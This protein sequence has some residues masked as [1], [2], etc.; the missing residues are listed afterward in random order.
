VISPAEF[1]RCFLGRRLWAKQKTMLD[2]VARNRS[3]AVKGCHGSGKSYAAAGLVC[4]E[5]TCH[6]EAIVLVIAPTLRQVKTF[7]AEVS[8]AIAQLKYPVPDATT[9]MWQI[10]EKRYAQGFSSSKG[11]N[12]QGFHGR[13]VLI[14]ADEAIGITSDIW[15]AIEGIRSA[16]DVKL[17]TLCNPTVPS[18]PV[19]ESFTR[20]RSVPGHA[21]ITISAFDTPNLAGLTMESLLQL[22]ED[23]LDYAPFPWLTRRRWVKEMWFKWGPTNP[24]FQS[25]VLGEFPTQASDAVFELAWI[26]AAAKPYEPEDMRKLVKPGCFIQIGVDVAGPGEDETSA[27][28]RIGGYVLEQAAWSK[29]DAIDETK[30]FI[31]RQRQR[32]SGA[33]IVVVVDIVGMGFHFARQ[34]AK[35]H[36][37]VRGFVAG[38]APMD[39]VMFANAKAEQYWVLREWMRDGFIHGVEDEDTKA[40]LSDIRYRETPRGRIEIEGKD[41]ARA[42]GSRSP[43]RAESLV[44]SFCRLI[45]R[46][47]TILTGGDYQISPV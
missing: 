21:C 35:E 33:A 45:P 41:E 38:A 17:V 20:G 14:L 15:D 26:E 29:P 24:R 18:G 46:E 12:A 34:L 44:M 8:G 32:F 39:P 27:T 42:R 2:A 7:W 31:H 3:V 36:F 4:S 6:D 40:Q 47:Q 30:A 28:A 16:G 37:D 13:R 1:Q 22:S 19:F 23:E 5:L 10:S 43:D 25:R 9:T 11:V